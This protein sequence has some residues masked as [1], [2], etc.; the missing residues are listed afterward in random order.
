MLR[1]SYFR[2]FSQ[3][4]VSLCVHLF[5]DALIFGLQNQ[6]RRIEN[7]NENEATTSQNQSH[8]T[9]KLNARNTSARW[10]ANWVDDFWERE[11]RVYCMRW[12]KNVKGHTHYYLFVGRNSIP[13]TDRFH[14]LCFVRF[15]QIRNYHVSGAPI[16]T[17]MRVD[18]K[19]VL[20]ALMIM[21]KIGMTA[22]ICSF[23]WAHLCK[24]SRLP[25]RQV[26]VCPCVF[27][28]CKSV[29]SFQSNYYPQSIP[30][31]YIFLSHH[32]KSHPCFRFRRVFKP[33]KCGKNRTIISKS[34]SS[35][36]FQMCAHFCGINNKKID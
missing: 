25:S 10:T 21:M 22:K 12:E 14:F 4:S 16:H 28:Y 1:R 17:Q 30:Y 13:K 6:K 2:L 35:Q 15:P 23:V 18:A 33:F 24:W 31:E 7:A 27:V 34:V 26:Y 29:S 20:T 36:K 5:C 8:S 19:N 9:F 11:G 32:Q 3:F